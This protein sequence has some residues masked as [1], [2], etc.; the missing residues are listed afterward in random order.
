MKM[1]I[2][3]PLFSEAEKTYNYYI[4]NYLSRYFD[5]YLPQEDGYLLVDL[6]KQEIDPSLAK[7]LI[8]DHDIEAIESS[9]ILLIILDGRTIDE[10]AAFELGY[11]Y[12]LNKKCIALQTDPRRLLS[13]GNN[14]M[15]DCALTHIFTSVEQIVN[16]ADDTCDKSKEVH[17]NKYCFVF[18]K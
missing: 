2:A 3:A 18:G 14:P 17:L 6:L 1:Y 9:D 10:G 8:F 16:W 13:T 15:I 11:A 12:S 7:K 5:I 4:K